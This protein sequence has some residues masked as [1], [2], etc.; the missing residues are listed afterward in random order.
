MKIKV[1][2]NNTLMFGEFKFKC[3]VGKNGFSQNKY[4]GDKKTPIGTFDLGSIY[5]RDDKF[6]RLNTNL[7]TIKIRKNMGWC[8]DVNSKSKYNKFIR[9]DKNIKHEKLYRKDCKYD[10]LI[11][12]KYNH[13]KTILNKGSCIFLHLTKN[14]KPT[15]GCIALS[16]NDFLI[17]IR[18]INKKTKI[19][20]L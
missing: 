18:I 9:I 11:P 16:K 13:K 5:Y 19:Q 7:E 3:C 12:I 4:E 17:L 8:D 14:Y 20:I 6:E 2:R 15:A 1:L 10:L